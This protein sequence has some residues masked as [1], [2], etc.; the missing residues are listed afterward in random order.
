MIVSHKGSNTAHSTLAKWGFSLQRYRNWAL[1]TRFSRSTATTSDDFG[2]IPQVI[3]GSQSIVI[4]D[5]I[6]LLMLT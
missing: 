6:F 1:E 2:S 5:L 4:Y 3:K